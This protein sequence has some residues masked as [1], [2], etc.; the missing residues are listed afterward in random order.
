MTFDHK[1]FIPN[2]PVE[3]MALRLPYQTPELRQH[4]AA[5]MCSNP[6]CACQKVVVD[7]VWETVTYVGASKDQRGHVTGHIIR[8]PNGM[9]EELPDLS[10]LRM[11]QPF[12]RKTSR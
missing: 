11:V 2:M 9:L 4:Q 10:Q 5:H 12:P 8:Y 7:E 1:K 6:D 3:V